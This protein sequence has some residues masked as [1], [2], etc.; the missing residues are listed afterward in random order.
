MPVIDL[1]P[2][3]GPQ[4]AQGNTGPQGPQGVAGPSLISAETQTSL[5]GALAGDGSVVGVRTIDTTPNSTHTTNLITSAAVAN[6]IE[7]ATT[8][9]K[10]T[11]T[12]TLES[13]ED[14]GFYYWEGT[15]SSPSD[16][17]FTYG[18]MISMQRSTVTY[19]Q[20]CFNTV[21]AVVIRNIYNGNDSRTISPWYWVSGCPMVDG[22]EYATAEKFNGKVVYCKTVAVGSMGTGNNLAAIYVNG[23]TTRGTIVRH[24]VFGQATATN[25]IGMPFDNG[26]TVIKVNPLVYS[27]NSG[28]NWSIRLYINSNTALTN[29]IAALW[30]TKD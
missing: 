26:D 16:I 9:K 23:L 2:V 6:A 21:G 25:W 3:V 27:G 29:V 8:T 18:F 4:G 1:G 24:S 7:S 10:L 30:Y 28:V 14:T 17:P 13:I 19:E 15:A 11:N 5:N 12:V 20:I 22:V